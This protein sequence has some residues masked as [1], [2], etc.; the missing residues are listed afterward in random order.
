MKVDRLLL[1]FM[2]YLSNY[3]FSP[4][5]GALPPADIP[6][7]SFETIREIK[8]ALQ[9]F[10]KGSHFYEENTRVILTGAKASPRISTQCTLQILRVII[11]I[12]RQEEYALR[13]M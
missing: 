8:E 10:E 7:L 4:T 9:P 12:Q 2:L 6:D 1:L 5:N 3:V 11:D 13:G